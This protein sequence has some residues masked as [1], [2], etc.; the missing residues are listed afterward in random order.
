MGR[1]TTLPVTMKCKMHGWPRYTGSYYSS[2][3]SDHTAN[4]AKEQLS[5][6]T[7]GRGRGQQYTA[8]GHSEARA[9]AADQPQGCRTGR[10]SKG[11]EA[12][13]NRMHSVLPGTKAQSP[14]A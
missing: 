4:R 8:M 13:G 3:P 7:K 11:A 6:H 9:A 12:E 14:G 5:S 2:F 10:G 1:Q